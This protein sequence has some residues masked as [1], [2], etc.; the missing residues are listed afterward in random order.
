MLAGVGA[1][2][3]DR[4]RIAFSSDR[5][6]SFEVYAM[7]ADGSSVRQLTDFK[8][9]RPGDRYAP[10]RAFDGEPAWSPD[11]RRLAFTSRSDDSPVHILYVANFDG[12]EASAVLV[13]TGVLRSPRWSRDGRWLTFGGELDAPGQFYAL[14]LKTL[15]W[16]RVVP[17]GGSDPDFSPDMQKLAFVCPAGLGGICVVNLDGTHLHALTKNGGKDGYPRWSPDGTRILFTRGDIIWV[18]GADGSDLVRLRGPNC[19]RPAWSPAGGRIVYSRR[20]G[21]RL[22]VAN[23]R[24]P[25]EDVRGAG[26]A[27]A[28]MNADGS[29]EV[30][31]TDGTSVDREPDWTQ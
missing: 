16:T 27:V 6:G 13:S 21:G 8:T 31:A 12:S 23:G 26:E 11:G 10:G 25:I 15:R 7:N 9:L 1:R 28:I 17:A 24:H 4:G 2:A 14:Q 18:M 29:Q 20:V 22:P 30:Q 3:Q 19:A 5:G